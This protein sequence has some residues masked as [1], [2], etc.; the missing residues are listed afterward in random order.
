MATTTKSPEP[1]PVPM[2][3]DGHKKELAQYAAEREKNKPVLDACLNPEVADWYEKQKPK[4]QFRVEARWME[5][6]NAGRPAPHEFDVKV[7]AQNASDAWS[8]ACDLVQHWPSRR[9]VKPTITQLKQM[10]TG[11]IGPPPEPEE[12]EV[13]R[14]VPKK[15]QSAR[16]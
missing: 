3:I 11:P 12:T 16:I 7:T 15:R 6:N 4:H 10:S 2:D 5:A 1:K 14:L 13:V 9:H 8:E